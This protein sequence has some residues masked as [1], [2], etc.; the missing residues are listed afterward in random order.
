MTT[1]DVQKHLAQGRTAYQI[2]ALFKKTP[3]A[4]YYHMDKIG[5]PRR[6]LKFDPAK[7]PAIGR[8][9]HGASKRD[10]NG[11]RWPEYEAYIGAKGRCTNPKDKSFLNYGERGIEFRFKDFE[12]FIADVGRRPSRRHT[13]ERKNN[14]GH[15]EPGNCCWATMSEQLKNRRKGLRKRLCQF[16]NDELFKECTRRGWVVQLA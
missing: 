7:H 8:T 13:L 10:S 11:K 6:R 9:L 3:S 12:Q 5:A 16:T 14:N 4:V 2:A 1:A 15:Y